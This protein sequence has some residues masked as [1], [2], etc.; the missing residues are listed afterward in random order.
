MYIR[1]KKTVIKQL[2]VQWEGDGGGLSCPWK[3]TSNW[4]WIVA[5]VIQRETEAPLIQR[6]QVQRYGKRERKGGIV[7]TR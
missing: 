5:S 1:K 2:Y 3:S 7:T 4:R 6:S